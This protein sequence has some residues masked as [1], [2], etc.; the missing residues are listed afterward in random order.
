MHKM[1]FFGNYA[2]IHSMKKILFICHANVTRSQMTAGFFNKNAPAGWHAES[3][4]TDIK[5]EDGTNADK[6]LLKETPA[7]VHIFAC[8]AEEGIDIRENMRH[9]V[10]PQM[11]A[12]ADMV[13]ALVPP[14]TCPDYMRSSPKTIYW[15]VED[16]AVVS[17]DE[18]KKVRERIRPLVKQLIESL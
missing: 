18:F 11:I 2:T 8:M 3:A 12:D 14:E 1:S 17:L 10:T 9:Q 7:T 15:N 5:N 4:G 6:H 16:I 13:I